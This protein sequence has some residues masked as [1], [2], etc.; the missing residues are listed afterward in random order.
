M[1][2]KGAANQNPREQGTQTSSR[3]KCIESKPATQMLRLKPNI[4]KD[5]SGVA[6]SLLKSTIKMVGKRSIIMSTLVT[7]KIV[8]YSEF[9]II[10]RFY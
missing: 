6:S 8:W 9:I 2:F 10:L 7:I 1:T 3:R 5:K 4:V